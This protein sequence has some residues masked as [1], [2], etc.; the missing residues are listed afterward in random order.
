MVNKCGHSVVKW[1][2]GGH[3][4]EIIVVDH[5]D[6]ANVCDEIQNSANG[7][8][9][10][11]GVAKK[12]VRCIGGANSFFWAAPVSRLFER[13]TDAPRKLK[14]VKNVSQIDVGLK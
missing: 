8:S 2:V 14:K 7:S 11:V 1:R 3:D 12:V 10:L 4:R 6:W 13:L 5:Q 9:C